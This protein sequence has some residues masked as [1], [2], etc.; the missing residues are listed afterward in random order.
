M[1]FYILLNGQV[2]EHQ[3]DYLEKGTSRRLEP[4][5]VAGKPKPKALITDKI[6]NTFASNIMQKDVQVIDQ[7]EKIEK[8]VDLIR[9]YQFHHLPVVNKDKLV[10]I[11]S[12]RDILWAQKVQLTS[13]FDI[14]D[15]MSSIVILSDEDSPIDHLAMVLY[16][17]KIHAL[18]I[19]DEKDKLSGI[20]SHNDIL[21]WLFDQ[22]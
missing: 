22:H 1:A 3:F 16:R 15:S 8:A 7:N 19:I 6:I 14:H 13:I 11:V 5:L 21:R 12:D 10:G 4:T 20:V 17:E 2:K 18:P 9:K